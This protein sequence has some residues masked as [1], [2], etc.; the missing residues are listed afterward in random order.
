MLLRDLKCSPTLVTMEQETANT[1]CLKIHVSTR[2]TT[3][4]S[5]HVVITPCKLRIGLFCEIIWRKISDSRPEFDMN[6]RVYNNVDKT[7]PLIQACKAANIQEVQRLFSEG[8]ASPFDRLRGKQSLL[9][10]ILERMVPLPMR[11]DPEIALENMTY[12]RRTGHTLF[13]YISPSSVPC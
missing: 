3:Q 4:T 13:S 10:V 8:K 1:H 9:D 6:L 7:A 12:Q 11:Q 5:L 2:K